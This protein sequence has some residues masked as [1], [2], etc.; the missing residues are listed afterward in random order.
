VI[1]RIGDAV[2]GSSMNQQGVLHVTARRVGKDTAISQASSYHVLDTR[3]H[4]THRL[5]DGRV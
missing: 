4:T 2:F 5:N 3:T 1:K